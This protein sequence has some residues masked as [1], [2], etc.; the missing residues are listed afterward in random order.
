MG[1]D[2]YDFHNRRADKL[3]ILFA[4]RQDP[5]AEVTRWDSVCR[6]TDRKQRFPLT[7]NRRG[8]GIP[9][10]SDQYKVRRIGYNAWR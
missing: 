9:A 10:H 5:G 7:S 2:A 3:R 8:G 4:S 1:G 6:V